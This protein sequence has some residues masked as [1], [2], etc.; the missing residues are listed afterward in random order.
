MINAAEISMQRV[1]KNYQLHTNKFGDYRKQNSRS[2]LCGRKWSRQILTAAYCTSHN[3]LQQI[4]EVTVIF[5]VIG[6]FSL[7]L[8]GILYKVKLLTDGELLNDRKPGSS[9]RLKYQ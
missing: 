9:V 4:Y 1:P 3:Q 7:Y 6:H 2:A 8:S 5:L